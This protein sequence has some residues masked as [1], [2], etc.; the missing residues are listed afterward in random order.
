MMF[1]SIAVTTRQTVLSG[2]WI[3][4]LVAAILFLVAVALGVFLRS[5]KW[6]GIAVGLVVTDLLLGGVI[7]MLDRFG[8][9][10]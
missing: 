8:T 2:L 6:W 3:A 10:R 1:A 7:A 4:L 9:A 5:S